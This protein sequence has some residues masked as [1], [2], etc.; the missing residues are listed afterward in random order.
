MN[1]NP[2]PSFSCYMTACEL[3]IGIGLVHII[4]KSRILSHGLEAQN[5]QEVMKILK[6]NVIFG[7]H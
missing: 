3:Y 1:L 7:L 5:N 2:L 4:F 6:R